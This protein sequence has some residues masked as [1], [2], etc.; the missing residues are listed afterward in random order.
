[1]VLMAN[2]KKIDEMIMFIKAS[3]GGSGIIKI[4]Q[5]EEDEEDDIF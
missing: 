5:E 4:P 2:K 1:M 3:E